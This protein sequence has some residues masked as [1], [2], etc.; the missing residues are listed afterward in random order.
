[1]NHKNS[2]PLADFH[3]SQ[4]IY[5]D[6]STQNVLSSPFNQLVVAYFDSSTPNVL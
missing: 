5:F 4:W 6:S 2:N 1:M 3:T